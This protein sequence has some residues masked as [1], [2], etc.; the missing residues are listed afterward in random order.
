MCR[1][2]TRERPCRRD[3]SGKGDYQ[4]TVFALW[5]V[6]HALGPPVHVRHPSVTRY[7]TGGADLM[8][9]VGGHSPFTLYIL[10]WYTTNC[11]TMHIPPLASIL[12]VLY[13]SRSL[14]V[15]K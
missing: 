6:P 4:L 9:P 7:L 11:L 8:L 5:R 14:P 12:N 1:L 2:C 15:E 3:T 10:Y 13:I